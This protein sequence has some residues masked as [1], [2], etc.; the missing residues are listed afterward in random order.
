MAFDLKSISTGRVDLPP[1]II[2]LGT[3]K[4]GKSTFGCSAP[5]VIAIPI[6]G[7]EGVDD[8]DCAKFPTAKTFDDVLAAL[9]TLCEEEH[10]YKYV[11]LDSA[12]TLEP[13]VWDLVCREVGDKSGK[14]VG[15]IELV[16]GG[17]GKGYTAALQYWRQIM[18]TLDYL[19][20]NKGV[21]SIITGHVK[22]KV[23]NDP[24]A[25][26]YDQ[27]QWDI[28]Q[29]AA[30]ALMKWADVILFARFQQYTRTLEDTGR[31]GKTPDKVRAS[32]SGDR[33]L[34]TQERPA[35]PG[36]ARGIYGHV[37]YELPLSWAA[38]TAAVAAAA[39]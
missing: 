13:M 31:D 38:W 27:F 25:E 15:N 9:G 21:G 37:P 10:P 20:T 36:G 5:G 6:K 14:P 2:I 7:E 28:Q 4:V 33:K 32:G 3:P 39:K 29:V 30:S 34:Y 8:M 12:S 24:L 35:H 23:F 11:M 16:G 19:R 26:P 1:R 17:Y 18:H 22:V